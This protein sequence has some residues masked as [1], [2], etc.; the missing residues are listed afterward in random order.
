MIA[1][2]AKIPVK[3]EKFDVAVEAFKQLMVD[4]AKEEGTLFYSLNVSKSDPNTLVVM[5]RYKDKDA[6]NFH[7]STP[8]FKA[9]MAKGAELF[10]GRPEILFFNELASI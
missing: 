4:V 6:L 10:S 5:E 3:E 1:V 9:F 7:S 8:H 2:V